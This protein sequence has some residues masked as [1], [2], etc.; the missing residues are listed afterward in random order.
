MQRQSPGVFPV[1]KFSVRDEAKFLSARHE[2]LFD[3]EF[4]HP[5]VFGLNK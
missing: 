1:A 3:E 2:P 5:V 4:G